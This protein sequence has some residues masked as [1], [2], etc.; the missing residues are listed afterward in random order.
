MTPAALRQLTRLAEAR[1]ARDLARL[2]GLL[3]RERQLAAEISALSGTLAR[4]LATGIAL[5]PA[6]QALRQAWVEQ[7]IRAAERQRTALA[8]G[9]VAARA[10]AVQSLGK[11]RALEHLVERG[12][13]IALQHDLARAEREAPPAAARTD[14]SDFGYSP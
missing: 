3:I 14:Q 2:E 10:E 13:R 8:A 6:Q 4:D 1:K 12:D 7:R 9:I 11:H 5:P